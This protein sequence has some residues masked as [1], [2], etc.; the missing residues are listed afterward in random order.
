MEHAK[1]YEKK[2]QHILVIY[3]EFGLINILTIQM[4]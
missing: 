2:K 3:F 4:K 1:L